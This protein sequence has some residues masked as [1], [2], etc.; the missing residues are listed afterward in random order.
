MNAE[1]VTVQRVL[2]GTGAAQ[3]KGLLERH[4]ELT[5]SAAGQELLGD[6]EAALPRFWQLVPPSEANTPEASEGAE[7]EA[8]DGAGAEREP[9]AAAAAS[10]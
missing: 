7:G 9:A 2:T 8:G 6:W 3:L 5:G 1:I 10:A 4:V